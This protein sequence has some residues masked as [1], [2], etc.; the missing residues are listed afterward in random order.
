MP[1][2]SWKYSADWV[3]FPAAHT[4]ASQPVTGNGSWLVSWSTSPTRASGLSRSEV[5]AIGSS[6]AEKDQDQG[7]SERT[8]A[9]LCNQPIFC[10][11]DDPFWGGKVA[12]RE[13]ACAAGRQGWRTGP[14]PA[15]P[16]GME[17]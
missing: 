3:A 8:V 7:S 12:M 1:K 11:S 2:A 4:T 14:R 17:G 9:S 10:W 15:A 13:A 16:S 6:A 5:A